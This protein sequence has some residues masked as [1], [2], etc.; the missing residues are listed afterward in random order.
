MLRYCWDDTVR[1]VNLN[2]ILYNS[3]FDVSEQAYKY[4]IDYDYKKRDIKSLFFHNVITLLCEELSGAVVDTNILFYGGMSFS[5]PKFEKACEFIVKKIRTL[6]P[7]QLIESDVDLHTFSK[8][9]D[10]KDIDSLS[11]MEIIIDKSLSRDK[12]SYTLQRLKSF[13][14]RYNLVYLDAIYF[15]QLH[16]KLSILT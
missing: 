7:L 10:A 6:L 16:I 14:K 12:T 5:D 15:K 11:K 4:A 8:L 13:L 2:N 3:Y 9:L 1:V